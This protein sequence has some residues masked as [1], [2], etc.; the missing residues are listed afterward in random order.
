MNATMSGLEM[1]F[2]TLEFE[3]LGNKATYFIIKDDCTAFLKESGVQN[4]ILIAQSPHTTCAVFYEEMVHDIDALGDEFLQADLNK[5]LEKIFPKQ[6]AYDDYYKYPGPEHRAFSRDN[7][8]GLS[9]SKAALLNGDAHLKSTLLG[10]SQVIIIK[11]GELMTGSYGYLYFVDFDGN[12]PRKR[13]CQL[14]IIGA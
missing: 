2:K 12:R 4:G 10:A 1:H 13:T 9:K 7:G 11:N 3:T 5:G 8:G 6:L 14:C